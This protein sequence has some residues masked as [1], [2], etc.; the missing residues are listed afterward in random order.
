MPAPTA[1]RNDTTLSLHGDW[2][3]EHVAP[4]CPQDLPVHSVDLRG[5][6]H[7]DSSLVAYLWQLKQR[8]DLAKTPF[9]LIGAPENLPKLF[10]LG[11]SSACAGALP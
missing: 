9:E 3:L 5:V 4:R 10:G 7:W 6:G 1:T 11:A 8:A 2:L